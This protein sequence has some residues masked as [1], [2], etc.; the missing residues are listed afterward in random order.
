M[1]YVNVFKAHDSSAYLVLVH[2]ALNGVCN[3]SGIVLHLCEDVI[4]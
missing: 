3:Q 2:E 4:Q 1:G